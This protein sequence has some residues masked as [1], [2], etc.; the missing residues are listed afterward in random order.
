MCQ[1]SRKKRYED[2]RFNVVSVS[3]GLVSEMFQQQKSYE[4]IRFKVIKLRG[5]SNFQKKNV[6]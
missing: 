3:K 4:D 1:I 5:V 2:V 6:L